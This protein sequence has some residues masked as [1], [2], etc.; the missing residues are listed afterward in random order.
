[1]PKILLTSQAVK[2]I[3]RREER[4]PLGD[5]WLQKPPTKGNS[6]IVI[7]I[8]IIIGL[9]IQRIYIVPPQET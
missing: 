2:I 8:I 3:I 9:F 7:I 1:V 5:V 4:L 6:V